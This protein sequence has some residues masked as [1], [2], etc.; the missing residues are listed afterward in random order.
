MVR[1]KLTDNDIPII[2]QLLNA[3]HSLRF[4]ARKFN[5]STNTIHTIGRG[6]TWKHIEG[7]RLR[8]RK[9]S[10]YYGVSKSGNQWEAYCRLG[11]TKHYLGKFEVEEEA[12]RTVNNFIIDQWLPRPLNMIPE[13]VAMVRFPPRRY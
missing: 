2:L 6:E 9:S 13:A 5:V 1:P 10:R 11:H 8:R 3:G 7:P 4:I 12:A